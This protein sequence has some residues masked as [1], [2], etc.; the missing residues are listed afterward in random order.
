VSTVRPRDDL[1]DPPL[2]GVL[3]RREEGAL[4]TGWLVVLALALAAGIAFR[5]MLPETIEFKGDEKF[6]FD[7]VVNVLHGGAWP[8]HGM[9]MSI[10]GPNPGMSVWVFI[11]LG[12]VFRPETPPDLARVVQLLNVAAHVAF[13]AFI[14]TAI[15]RRQRDPWLWGLALWAV[16]PLAVIHERKIWPPSVLPIFM[17]AMLCGWWYRRHWLGS[18]LFAA[19][20]TLA[21]QIHPTAGFLG[22]AILVWTLFDDRRCFR[23]TG[24]VAGAAIGVLPAITWILRHYEPG[25]RL[26]KL[27]PPWLTFYGR[28][29]TE[30]FGFGADHTLGPIEFSRFVAGP[31]IGGQPTYLVLLLHVAIASL[32][33]SVL[34]WAAIRLY[35]SGLLTDRWLFL[36]ET[37]GGRLVRAAFFG[38]GT[39][40]TLL[41]IRG[42][43]LYPHYLIVI[44]PLMTL[45]VALTAA[46]ADGGTLAARGR[47][48]L[49]ALCVCDVVLVVL[50]F[51]YIDTKGN[52][53]GEFG[54]SWAWQQAQPVP[55]VLEPTE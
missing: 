51:A 10:G 44:V 52:I 55:S 18:F 27:R 30:P 23:V 49:A 22:V 48:L 39:I 1:L 9:R 50:L 35:R 5:L 17:V 36:G 46:F 11:L 54:P 16:N 40:L 34:A 42:G 28:W 21:G 31:L 38:F 14:M 41:T 53:S 45:W 43:G 6:T 8:P 4:A 33:I 19:V 7:H 15:P 13:L 12:Q 3:P 2:A 25:D 20:A 47:T 37:A 29:F 26:H 32:A 24:L